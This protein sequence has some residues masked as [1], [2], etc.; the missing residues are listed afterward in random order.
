LQSEAIVKVNANLLEITQWSFKLTS[1]GV[2]G[3]KIGFPPQKNA[4]PF[5]N[6]TYP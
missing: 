2:P 4:T 5:A 3:S 6:S 1:A